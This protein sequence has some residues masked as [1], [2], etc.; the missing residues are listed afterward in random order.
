MS[1][2]K[3]VSQKDTLGKILRYIRKYWF[4]VVL[5]LVLAALTVACTLYIPILTGDAVDLIIDKGLVDMPAI[6]TI[7]KRTAVVMIVTAIAQWV[8]NTCNNYITYH[9]IK[10]IR[11]DAFAKLEILPLKYIDRQS[12][13][14]V[15]SRIIDRKSTR[16]NSSH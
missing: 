13:G 15:V 6:F 3:K 16:L 7:M 10:D 1:K 2:E 14:D 8:M 12:Y 11:Q 5:S 4:F 9:V